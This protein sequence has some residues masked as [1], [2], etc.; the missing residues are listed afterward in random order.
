[1]DFDDFATLSENLADRLTS[2]KHLVAPKEIEDKFTASESLRFRKL[3][4]HYDMDCGM[5]LAL[6]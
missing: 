5:S 6:L 1:M 2:F 3:F 4:A